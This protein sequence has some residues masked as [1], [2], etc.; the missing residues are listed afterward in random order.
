MDKM[1]NAAHLHV[2]EVAEGCITPFSGI[3][4]ELFHRFLGVLKIFKDFEE[5][6][7]NFQRF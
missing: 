3:F 7:R 6:V 4:W 2:S 1:F 5:F